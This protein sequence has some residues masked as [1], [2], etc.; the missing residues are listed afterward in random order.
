MDGGGRGT[1]LGTGVP[2]LAGGG[3]LPWPGG[4]YFGWGGEKYQGKY[5]PS[6]G[7][8]RHTRRQTS[9]QTSVK[10]LLSPILRIRAVNIIFFS[11]RNFGISMHTDQNQLEL[12]TQ[13]LAIGLLLVPK[14]V[15]SD[16]FIVRLENK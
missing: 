4:T 13:M 7:K 12:S 11:D 15:K 3:Y 14:I 9:K 1:Y 16:S 5:P 8:L 6:T 10:T 2:T